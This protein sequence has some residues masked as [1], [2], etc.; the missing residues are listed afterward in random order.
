MMANR[1]SSDPDK[2]ARI[3]FRISSLSLMHGHAVFTV[4]LFIFVNLQGNREVLFSNFGRLTLS[5]HP[6]CIFL[7]EQSIFKNS[8]HRK[9]LSDG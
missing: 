1:P 7:E 6:C 5:K 4:G 2:V 8:H 3:K 9:C